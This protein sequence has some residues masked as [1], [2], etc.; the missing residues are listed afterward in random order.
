[1][2]RPRAPF[3]TGTR[4][5]LDRA[6]NAEP[7]VRVSPKPQNLLHAKLLGKCLAARLKEE[8]TMTDHEAR[9]KALEKARTELED[10]FLVMTHLETKQSNVIRQQAEAIDQIRA[11]EKEQRRLNR[12]ENEEHRKLNRETDLR[13]A[14]LVSA[15]GALIRQMPPEARP[16]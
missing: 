3:N 11:Q 10:S 6:F 8:Q 16:N 9:V 13:I 15:I 5:P 14:D 1:M 7:V 4:L 12:L 2:A